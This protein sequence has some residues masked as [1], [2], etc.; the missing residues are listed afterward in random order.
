MDQE[1]AL[2]TKGYSIAI[3]EAPISVGWIQ[4]LRVSDVKSISP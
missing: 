3:C 1:S 2:N 4:I